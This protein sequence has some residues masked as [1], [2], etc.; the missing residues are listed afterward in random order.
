MSV[1]LAGYPCSAEDSRA[2]PVLSYRSQA[3][4]VPSNESQAIPVPPIGSRAIP[5]RVLQVSPTY[6]D[7]VPKS[8]FSNTSILPDILPI[9]QFHGEPEIFP[10]LNINSEDPV[11]SSLDFALDQTPYLLPDPFV[12][13]QS[14]YNPFID[15][16]LTS[17]GIIPMNQ[18]FMADIQNDNKLQTINNINIEL[19]PEFGVGFQYQDH[20]QLIQR[21]LEGFQNPGFLVENQQLLPIETTGLNESMSIFGSE[22]Q[23]HVQMIQNDNNT[24]G[25]EPS[26]S[27]N[28]A[29]GSGR[30]FRH[31][32]SREIIAEHFNEPIE[33]AAK[34]LNIG[35]TQLKK[36]CRDLGI[37]RWPQRQLKSLQTLIDR[38]EEF[39]NDFCDASE[40]SRDLIPNLKKEKE[41]I[42]EG[43]QSGLTDGTKKLIQA[44]H[45]VVF[46]KRKIQEKGENS[47]RTHTQQQSPPSNSGSN[48]IETPYLGAPP[49]IT[50]SIPLPNP[51]EGTS[52]PNDDK[53]WSVEDLFLLLSDSPV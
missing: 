31:L 24:I 20:L 10:E 8:A 22:N 4:S 1:R 41:A 49:P 32:L 9:E 12:D 48:P 2:V 45:K 21:N 11:H 43:S 52:Q 17:S 6:L 25:F 16:P 33:K 18:G 28:I 14:D 13:G 47:S 53:D 44:A 35:S 3:F 38:A 30:G 19:N 37:N 50:E 51:R 46:R 23:D 39:G 5:I 26:S 15:V 7:F 34:E 29:G 36:C 42:I 40:L 27:E